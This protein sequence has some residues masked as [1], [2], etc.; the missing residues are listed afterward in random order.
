MPSGGVLRRSLLRL[1]RVPKRYTFTFESQQSAA[2]DAG[3]STIS[4]RTA[5]RAG[6]ARLT[7]DQSGGMNLT[8]I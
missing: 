5:L 1:I 8:R 2:G 4:R 6:P 3:P 7:L